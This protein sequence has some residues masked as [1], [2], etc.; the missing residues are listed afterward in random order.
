[1]STIF[2]LIVFFLPIKEPSHLSRA[3][4]SRFCAPKKRHAALKYLLF[5]HVRTGAIIHCSSPYPEAACE[6]S[7][8]KG[9]LSDQ[10]LPEERLL[11]D[12]GYA[13]WP[14]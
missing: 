3:Q 7:I 9:E 2:H 8:V 1:M 5:I 4:R 6:A 10:L 14:D 13:L 11:G 12:S